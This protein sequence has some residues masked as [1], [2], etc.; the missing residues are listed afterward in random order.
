MPAVV[1]PRVSATI[2]GGV[3]EAGLESPPVVKGLDE[4]GKGS[5]PVRALD[6]HALG[7]HEGSRRNRGT[8]EWRRKSGALRIRSDAD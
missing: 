3:P 2:R 4:L 7:D 1:T 5:Q 6:R 8:R